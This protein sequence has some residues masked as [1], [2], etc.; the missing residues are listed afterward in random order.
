MKILAKLHDLQRQQ[1]KGHEGFG[2][3]I[4]FQ[5]IK[6]FS[7]DFLADASVPE[8]CNSGLQGTIDSVNSLRPS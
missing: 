1:C 3:N 5:C 2:L 8:E 4:L 6:L 7:L